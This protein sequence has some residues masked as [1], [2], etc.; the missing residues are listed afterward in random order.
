MDKFSYGSFDSTNTDAVFTDISY[1]D[2]ISETI[3]RKQLSYPLKE[4]KD[5]I[6][7]TVSVDSQDNALQLKLDY[8]NSALYYSTDGSNFNP[9][10]FYGQQGQPGQGVASGGTEGQVLVKASDTDYDTEWTTLDVTAQ[11]QSAISNIFPIGYVYISV[12]PTSPATYFGGTWVQITTDAYLKIVTSNGGV[13][14]GTSSAH[15]I[16]LSS[17]PS[18]THTVTDTYN[19]NDKVGAYSDTSYINRPVISTSSTRTTSSAGSGNAYYPY[20]VGVYVWKRTA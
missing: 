6:N 15:K 17:I 16:P 2:P 11:I 7:K 14:G 19:T 3:T 20:Y 8:E 18:H 9:V 5:Y 1:T 13:A 4:L 10:D 12:S